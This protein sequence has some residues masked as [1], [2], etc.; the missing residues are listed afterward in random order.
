[1]KP[2]VSLRI[3]GLLKRPGTVRF[4]VA[5][6]VEREGGFLS[7]LGRFVVTFHLWAPI[8]MGLNFAW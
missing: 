2:N 5:V 3:R 6:V 4:T 1:M 8:Q 7:L